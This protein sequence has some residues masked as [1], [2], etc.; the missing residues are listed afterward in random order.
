MDF[1]TED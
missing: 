1:Y